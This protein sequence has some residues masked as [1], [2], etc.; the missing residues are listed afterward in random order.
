[1]SNN[2]KLWFC[3]TVMVGV[4]MI[5]KIVMLEFQNYHT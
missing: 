2:H 1:M 5:K 4:I 3:N